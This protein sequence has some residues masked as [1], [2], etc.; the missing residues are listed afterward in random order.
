MAMYVF[1]HV[2]TDL[3]GYLKQ[4]EYAYAKYVLSLSLS[5]SQKGI[6]LALSSPSIQMSAQYYINQAKLQCLHP[7]VLSAPLTI[8]IANDRAMHSCVLIYSPC[9][10][11]YELRLN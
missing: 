10:C 11:T 6:S 4:H 7:R 1:G 2:Y 5:L 9:F 3:T 8:V